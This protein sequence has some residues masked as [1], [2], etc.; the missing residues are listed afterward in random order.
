MKV[1][2]I[3]P[4]YNVEDF[5]ERCIRSLMEQTLEDVEFIFVD[6]CSSDSSVDK[7]QETI[8]LYPSQHSRIKILSHSC[9]KGLPAA[10]NTGLKEAQG[11]YIFHCDSDDF[12][13]SNALEE[14]YKLAKE[15]N[16]DYV[17]SDWFLSFELNERYMKQPN[18]TSAMEALKGMLSGR[19]KFNVWNKLVK[20]SLYEQN[21]IYFPEGHDMGEDMTMIRL[22]TCAERVGHIPHAYYHYVR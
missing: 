1:S 16:A 10:R 11:E 9:N 6:D 18:Y 15:Q 19:M 3:V 12:L 5:I 13:E 7:L 17:W 22:L 21:N 4:V 2:I 20:R 8:V 14:M